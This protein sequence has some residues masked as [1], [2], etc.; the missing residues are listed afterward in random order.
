MR[1]FLV[2][3]LGAISFFA[4]GQVVLP[5]SVARFYLDRHFFAQSLEK[6]NSFL[7]LLT[8]NQDQTI[9]NQETLIKNYVRADSIHSLLEGNLRL[10]V[11]EGIAENKTLRKKIRNQNFIIVGIILIFTAITL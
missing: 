1:Y 6:R 3:I 9:Y 10:Q 7:I 2:A 4:P 5:D 8:E 11:Q